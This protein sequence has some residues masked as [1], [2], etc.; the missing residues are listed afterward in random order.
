MTPRP[1]LYRA[2]LNRLGACWP[3]VPIATPHPPPEGTRV[4]VLGIY[5][6]ARPHTAEHL[7]AAFARPGR[8]RVEQRWVALHGAP[9]TPLQRAHTVRVEGRSL[10]KF[11]LLNA[12]LRVVDP[13]PF[14]Y[15][16]VCDDD[17]RLPRGFLDAF[18]GWQRRLGF[19]LAQPART[20]NSHVD[21]E[22]V[23]QRPWL[24][25]R[26]TRFVEIGPLFCLQ[27]SLFDVL[28]PFDEASPMGWGYDFVWPLQ[29]EAA[30][31]TMG[32]IDATPVD[33]SLRGRGEAYGWQRELTAMSDYLAERPHLSARQAFRVLRRY[34]RFWPQRRPARPGADP[35]TGFGV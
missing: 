33:H 23:R 24:V 35:A 3:W 16:L 12:L 32:V 2:A 27:R 34:P 11:R 13:A 5:L 10:P 4:L 6:A 21:H 9:A 22:L 15:L 28:L 30:R 7:M 14:D 8:C 20:L 26:R 17:V 29:V 25:A 18:I 31:A 1:G 19:A